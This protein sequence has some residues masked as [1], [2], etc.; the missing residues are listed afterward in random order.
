ME[1]NEDTDQCVSGVPAATDRHLTIALTNVQRCSQTQF[2]VHCPDD[3][4]T[5]TPDIDQSELCGGPIQSLL[6]S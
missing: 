3:G 1:T 2:P 5:R 4:S 6:C